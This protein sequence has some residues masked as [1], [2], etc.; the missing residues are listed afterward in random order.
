MVLPQIMENPMENN[1]EN[2]METGLCKGY[3]VVS[4]NGGP[5]FRPQYTIIPFIGTP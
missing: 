3:M 5:Q 2:D 1:M 4:Q